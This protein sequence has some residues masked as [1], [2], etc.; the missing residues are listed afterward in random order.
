VAFLGIL[1]DGPALVHDLWEWTGQEIWGLLAN[2]P[3]W[4]SHQF[5]RKSPKLFLKDLG[6]K[7]RVWKRKLCKQTPDQ[8]DLE[9]ALDVSRYSVE[10][11]RRLALS[12][13]S[14][15]RYVPS[16]Y[17]GR[18][19]VLRARTQPLLSSHRPDLGW[20]AGA[21]QDVEV[22]VVSGDHNS[23][24]VEPDVK[25]LADALA[26]ALDRARAAAEVQPRRSAA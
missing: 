2:L 26:A 8:I 10:Y 12:Y 24:M 6:R 21:A 23:I 17:P 22:V 19:T 11:R 7:V 13:G 5:L 25:A 18:V 4:L 16:R 9:E 15:K 1:D 14:V 20:G 3:F